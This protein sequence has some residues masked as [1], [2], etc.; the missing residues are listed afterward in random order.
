VKNFLF[1]IL[2]F[3]REEPNFKALF[4]TPT[5]TGDKLSP[6]ERALKRKSR[7]FFFFLFYP[8][9]IFY[10][11]VVFHFA[12]YGE[13]PVK[14]LVYLALFSFATGFLINGIA[15]LMPLKANRI[16]TLVCLIISTL[17][18]ESQYVYF[19]FFKS[20]YR[21]ATMGMAGN[22]I[23]DFWRETL[24]TI[25]TSWFAIVLLL[26]PLIIFIKK[27][28]DYKPAFAP[29][30]AFRGYL[31]IAALVLHFIAVGIISLDN[32]DFGDRYYYKQEFSA[33]EATKRFGVL[34]DMRLDMKVTVF[35]ES[36]GDTPELPS[37]VDNPFETKT[38]ETTEVPPETTQ[39]IV[40]P[41]KPI[42]YGDNVM[43][44]DF[45]TLIAN[46]S[47]KDVKA[48]HEYF[49]SLTP[50]KKNE[51]T[52]LFKG[53]NL[54]YM[55]LEGFSYKTIDKERTPTLYKMAT[56]GFVFNNFYTSL[57][58]GSTA[59][60]EYT[61]VTGLFHNSA[62]CLGWSGDN[63]MPFTMGNQLSKIGY[64]TYAF[65]NH[66]HSYYSRDL[67]HPNF[68]YE[69]IAI[70]NGMEGL[71][72]CWPRSDHEMAVATLPY[73][74]DLETPWH[75]YY[76]TVSGHANYTFM[77]NNM[78]KKHRDIVEPL[79]VSENIK[80]YHA[81]QYEVELMLSEMVRQL[82][83][84]GILEDTVFVMSTDHYPYALSDSELAELYGLPEEG[85]HKNFDLLRNGCIIWCASMEEPVIIDTPASSLDILPTVS[86]LFGIEYDSRLLMGT[87]V[88]SG[89]M[90]L[91][92]LNQDG[93]GSAWNWINAYGEYSTATKKFTPYEGF[94][95]TDEEIAAYVKQM[96]A[97]VNYK[98]K[99]SKYILNEDYYRTL[100]K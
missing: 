34:T 31:I 17:L 39:E 100:F 59:T 71:T 80:A 14:T 60:G 47:N 46:E 18:I 95:A 30:F 99:F 97:V 55:T 33:T 15:L 81:C 68:G 37:D 38:P 36:E 57:W 9:S 32:S 88:L 41:P 48:A 24:A 20:F 49:S 25:S 63:V 52:G 2:K 82:D 43:D 65:H 70:G 16:F 73:Y 26:L 45:D 4:G 87:D 53:K 74:I 21:F 94:E 69:Y 42:E 91:V 7:N 8:L 54:I 84:K 13:M 44:I 6:R 1:K 22:A 29:T 76:M 90:P 3:F 35:G 92:I 66:T 28:G 78:A 61:S 58:G 98:N 10:M 40:E 77:G 96:N 50:T 75:A 86:N 93:D 23:T 67:S 89:T 27:L 72:N 51:Y 85:I 62:K 5:P 83:E 64:K 56:E 12:L 11:E 19:R 79:P